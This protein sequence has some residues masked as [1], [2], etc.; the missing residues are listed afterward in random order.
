MKLSDEIDA[1]IST[2]MNKER[3]FDM[4]CRVFIKCLVGSPQATGIYR[5]LEI[6]L[7]LIQ[8][9]NSEKLEGGCS[10]RVVLGTALREKIK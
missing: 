2:R 6:F 10:S 5:M 3:M 9:R 4:P 1:A 7:M 8:A